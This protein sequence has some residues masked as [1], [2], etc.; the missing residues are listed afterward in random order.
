MGMNGNSK[1]DE[2][3]IHTSDDDNNSMSIINRR[4]LRR[5]PRRVSSQQKGTGKYISDDDEIVE[6][7]SERKQTMETN[8][9]DN[10]SEI[11]EEKEIQRSNLQRSKLKGGRLHFDSL[12][13][14]GAKKTAIRKRYNN[15]SREEKDAIIQGVQK[16][17]KGKWAKIKRDSQF[18]TI[19]A[20]R[21]VVNIKDFY[22]SIMKQNVKK[23]D[24]KRPL[25]TTKSTTAVH[26]SVSDSVATDNSKD[27]KDKMKE[28]HTS[29]NDDNSI[30]T[31]NRRSSRVSSRQ[32]GINGN[33]K[34]DEE[35]TQRKHTS[36]DN[37]S[38]VDSV[39]TASS[40]DNDAAD[41][42]GNSDAS[43]TATDD[44][45]TKCVEKSKTST[46]KNAPDVSTTDNT[47]VVHKF[48]SA[49]VQGAV[50]KYTS[51]QDKRKRKRTSDDKSDGNSTAVDAHV[52]LSAGN[53]T[54]TTPSRKDDSTE[55]FDEDGLKLTSYE[56]RRQER[57]K[58]N[59][60]RLAQLGLL[61][62]GPKLIT[63]K[64]TPA[65]NKN[66]DHLPKRKTIPRQSKRITTY[67]NSA[68][69]ASDLSDSTLSPSDLSEV[70]SPSTRRLHT[71]VDA[72][73]KMLATR[74]T[75]IA[76]PKPRNPFN[77]LSQG[78]QSQSS[79]RQYLRV[80]ANMF[81]QHARLFYQQ[82]AFLD[83]ISINFDI[84]SLQDCAE[85]YESFQKSCEKDNTDWSVEIEQDK[86]RRES[87]CKLAKEAFETML[88]YR[89]Q[90]DSLLTPFT[91]QQMEDMKQSNQ[92]R[93]TS[94]SK[95][96]R[97]SSSSLLSEDIHPEEK[98][99]RPKRADDDDEQSTSSSFFPNSDTNEPANNHLNFSGSNLN[100][101]KQSVG[102]NNH[103][104]SN[105]DEDDESE[106]ESG[107][108]F[109]EDEDILASH[110]LSQDDD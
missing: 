53:T 94:S 72:K 22:R 73:S 63:Q 26:N 16:H 20:S 40:T 54:S 51:D 81:R 33:S 96:E 108:E 44:L 66:F 43:S 55:V 52:A 64:K 37:N 86:A 56:Q 47:A 10:D 58:Q 87:V 9:S 6:N 11:D 24:L 83:G 38:D 15:F 28:K 74:Q 98:R 29:D 103:A 99:K 49:I 25:E 78:Q 19:L 17:G 104:L 80:V 65:K 60:E 27:D 59:N 36:D 79:Q 100:M 14:T 1:G 106:E 4:S 8:D 77:F 97:S 21:T 91:K 76:M 85:S 18:S 82:A 41:D 102:N 67:T 23:G 48:T 2:D 71:S 92:H 32:K 34:V 62:T 57:I 110:I 69:S 84:S 3:S 50:E 107:E 12:S 39:V 75:P 93:N 31:P 88:Q 46:N 90:M 95:R 5:S 101:E 35:V 105:N 61:T 68:D 13:D 109:S 45:I 70:E 7:N 30:S 42:D 89:K